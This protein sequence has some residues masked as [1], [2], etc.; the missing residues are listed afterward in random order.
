ML[1]KCTQREAAAKL[2]IFL[3]QLHEILEIRDEIESA[4]VENQNKNR[5]NITQDE[6]DD[7]EFSVK[8][9]TNMLKCNIMQ[10]P[11]MN[12]MT[13]SGDH[14]MSKIKKFPNFRHSAFKNFL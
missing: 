9:P 11:S 14:C 6:I 1:E 12:T 8:I 3:S 13:T 7:D 10:S 2:G 4:C 5:N